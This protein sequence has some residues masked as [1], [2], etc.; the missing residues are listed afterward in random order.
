MYDM[1]Y[2]V[3]HES[4]YVKFGWELIM[5]GHKELFDIILNLEMEESIF[6]HNVKLVFIN[7]T[8]FENEK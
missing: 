3:P 6:L 8:L 4:T 2:Y 1:V 7:L 5:L